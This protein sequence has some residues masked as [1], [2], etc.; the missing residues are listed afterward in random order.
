MMTEISR[1]EMLYQITLSTKVEQELDALSLKLKLMS[2][3][4]AAKDLLYAKQHYFEYRDKPNK[5]V[6]KI[7]LE[8]VDKPVIMEVMFSSDGTLAT[9]VP[10]KLCLFM[11]YYMMLY[12]SQDPSEGD[13]KCFFENIKCPT[14]LKDHMVGL[15]SQ[16]ASSEIE[17]ALQQMKLCKTPRFDGL[18][19]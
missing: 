7:L 2:A 1:L 8:S 4:F 3:T 19:T 12:T 14:L 5:L 6:A 11:N 16:I 18:T 9:F 15:D 10:G 17:T 13:L